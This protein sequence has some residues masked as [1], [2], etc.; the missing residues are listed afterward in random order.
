MSWPCKAHPSAGQ[1]AAEEV[2]GAAEGVDLVV[3][4]DLVV[5]VALVVVAE[6]PLV[7]PVAEAAGP[8]V[9]DAD[10]LLA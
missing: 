8:Q 9:V 3:L 2:A 4:V 10:S 7:F 5:V 1:A 6:G